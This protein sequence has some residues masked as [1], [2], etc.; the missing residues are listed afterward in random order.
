MHKETKN[1]IRWMRTYFSDS[2]AG[3]SMATD[4]LL[5]KGADEI[6]ALQAN[7]KIRATEIERL[8]AELERVRTESFSM[9]VEKNKHI[10]QLQKDNAKLQAVVDVLEV[11]LDGD[12]GYE[13]LEEALAALKED[14]E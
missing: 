4:V 6:E 12:I 7:D 13:P 9:C 5:K 14:R 1:L 8:S 11:F 3:P 10:E 2:Y